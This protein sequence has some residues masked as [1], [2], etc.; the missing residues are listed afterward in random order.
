MKPIL[1]S[2]KD[3]E[4]EKE[5]G[6]KVG[7]IKALLEKDAILSGSREGN[8]TVLEG[9]SV[10]SGI[11]YS[12]GIEHTVLKLN[13]GANPKA[14]FNR[15]PV[16]VKDGDQEI[17]MCLGAFKKGFMPNVLLYEYE[18]IKL[19]FSTQVA[20]LLDIVEETRLKGR[21]AYIIDIPV[22]KA[23]SMLQEAT[24]L[25]EGHDIDVRLVDSKK[26]AHLAFTSL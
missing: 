2:K 3:I 5:R 13:A 21:K 15:L 26:K 14:D 17:R 12:L 16:I 19:D 9:S 7:R 20:L 1:R 23:K 24:T 22:G 10:I 4:E 11:L 8:V 6:D 18:R 25:S